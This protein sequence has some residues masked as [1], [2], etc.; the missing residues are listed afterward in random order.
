MKIGTDNNARFIQ[1]YVLQIK[2]KKE[3]L[4]VYDSSLTKL[5]LLTWYSNTLYNLVLQEIY[6]MHSR[7]SGRCFCAIPE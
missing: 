4:S 5:Y 7:V 6:E 3:S 1:N 2:K